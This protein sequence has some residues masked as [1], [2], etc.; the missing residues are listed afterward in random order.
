MS[1][2]FSVPFQ[3]LYT[4]GTRNYVKLKYFRINEFVLLVNH[5]GQFFYSLDSV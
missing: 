2:F 5:K 1:W 3:N 4:S